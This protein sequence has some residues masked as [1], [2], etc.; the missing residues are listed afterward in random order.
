[1]AVLHTTFK[2][3]VQISDNDGLEKDEQRI[4]LL[5]FRWLNFSEI[6]EPLYKA[7]LQIESAIGSTSR[8]SGFDEKFQFRSNRASLQWS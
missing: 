4:R 2:W 7:S 8:V 3:P 1:M 5:R 6:P